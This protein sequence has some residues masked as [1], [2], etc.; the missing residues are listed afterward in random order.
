ME[1]TR[2]RQ[3][4]DSIN[5]SVKHR[6]VI[7]PFGAANRTLKSARTEL[8]P[9]SELAELASAGQAA[10]VIEGGRRVKD[11]HPLSRH[12]LALTAMDASLS[13]R[14]RSGDSAPGVISL[15]TRRNV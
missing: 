10:L 8:L 7:E 1:R 6:G 2:L 11:A 3:R 4:D 12:V 15:E 9:E 13:D 5:A 14:T